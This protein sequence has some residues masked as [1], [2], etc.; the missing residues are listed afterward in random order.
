[1][2]DSP[3][4]SDVVSAIAKAGKVYEKLQAI[5]PDIAQYSVA[6]AYIQHWYINLTAREIYWI[7][8]LRTGPQGRPHYRK[9]A[10][11]IAGAASAVD[12]AVFQGI[13]VDW[14]EYSLSRRESEK[15][16]EAKIKNI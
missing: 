16:I 11:Q 3:F 5:S 14:N 10:Q 9:I 2:V 8:E 15:K 6:F 7:A 1:M 13:M 12:P 4:V